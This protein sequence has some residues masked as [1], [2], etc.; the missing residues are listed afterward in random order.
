MQSED[1]IG[2]TGW[3]CIN[4]SKKAR[5]CQRVPEGAGQGRSHLASVV[6]RP[7]LR[8]AQSSS[9]DSVSHALG[10]ENPSLIPFLLLLPKQWR[11]C[12]T[13]TATGVHGD[14][15]WDKTT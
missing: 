13:A 12:N 8:P 5:G 1:A 15:A 6:K 3:V 7:V 4:S 14:L 11:L 2:W 9:A 10:L